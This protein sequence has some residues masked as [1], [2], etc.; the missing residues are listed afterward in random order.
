MTHTVFSLNV[1]A[2]FPYSLPDNQDM[3]LPYIKFELLPSKK[4]GE[5][6]TAAR[7]LYDAR[8]GNHY[9]CVSNF[10]RLT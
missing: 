4:F 3:F 1:S 2:Y 5:M 6:E 7:N 9:N 10:L 8:K